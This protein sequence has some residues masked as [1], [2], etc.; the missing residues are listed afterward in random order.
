MTVRQALT[1]GVNLP[2]DEVGDPRIPLKQVLVAH[3]QE[4]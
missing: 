4:S 1:K 3:E 2:A